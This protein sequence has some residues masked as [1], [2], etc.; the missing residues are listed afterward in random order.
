MLSSPNKTHQGTVSDTQYVLQK[1]K[2][3]KESTAAAALSQTEEDSSLGLGIDWD[4]RH[5]ARF[6]KWVMEEKRA[7]QHERARLDIYWKRLKEER[8]RF[9]EQKKEFEAAEADLA[10]RIAQVKDLI[11][12]AAELKEIGFDFSLANSWLSCVKEMSQRKGLDIR[13]AAWKLA[14]DLK[15]WQELGG[16]ET[17]ISNSKHQL[18]LLDM[19]Q[20]D[21]K[22]EI[23]YFADLRKSGIAK[24]EIV[25]LMEIVKPKNNG[26]DGSG[27]ELDTKINLPKGR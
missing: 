16:F 15:S 12:L 13:S 24:R 6:V 22:E 10:Q 21:R 3:I 8:K 14:E 1:P 7:R 27:F 4:A 9:E 25:E 20:E 11:P 5:Q 18:F 19:A 26:H 2:E 23:A 17:A